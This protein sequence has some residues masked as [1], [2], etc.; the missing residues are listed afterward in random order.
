MDHSLTCWARSTWYRPWSERFRTICKIYAAPTIPQV[1]HNV[2]FPRKR[3]QIGTRQGCF[4]SHPNPFSL[5]HLSSLPFCV[6]RRTH[7]PQG[8]LGLLSSGFCSKLTL[9]K[10][11][12]LIIVKLNGLRA[13]LSLVETVVSHLKT[14]KCEDPVSFSVWAFPSLATLTYFCYLWHVTSHTPDHLNSNWHRN[15]YYLFANVHRKC[16]LWTER[17]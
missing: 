11:E 7:T 8:R 14:W 1:N 16:L 4:S 10:T 15:V 17:N 13:L 12:M 5:V 6:R 2:H 3:Q 9:K